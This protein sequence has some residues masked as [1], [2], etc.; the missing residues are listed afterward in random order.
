MEPAGLGVSGSDSGRAL[1]AGLSI[2]HGVCGL[3][4]KVPVEEPG[5]REHNGEDTSQAR[6]SSKCKIISGLDPRTPGPEHNI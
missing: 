3:P 5:S 6:R 1:E 2:G 4:Q